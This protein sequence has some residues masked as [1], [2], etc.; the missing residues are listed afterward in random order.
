MIGRLQGQPCFVQPGEAVL[1]VGGVGYRIR[2]TLGAFDRLS[3]SETVALWI[4]TQVKP[5]GI[6]LFGFFERAE[7][8][9]FERLITVAGVGPR[10]ALAVL[11]ALKP[12][13]LSQAVE[14]GQVGLLQKTPGVG[15]KTAERIVLELKGRLDEFRTQQIG[16]RGDAVSALVN[17]GYKERAARSAIEKAHE[18]SPEGNLAEILRLAL[19]RLTG[20]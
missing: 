18:E 6:E 11:S 20:Q 16:F 1:D 15:R 10:T 9:V 2:T 4:H 19:K 17:L 12:D 3:S 8:E 13:E 5:D 7:L 14:T